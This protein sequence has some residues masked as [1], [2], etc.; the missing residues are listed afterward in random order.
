MIY[1]IALASGKQLSPKALF[2]FSQVALYRA[3]RRLR[4][5]NIEV[6][7]ISISVVP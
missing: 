2:T 1:A 6:E 7:V 5:A 3:T 4:G